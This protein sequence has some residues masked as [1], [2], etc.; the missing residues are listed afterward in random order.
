M[1]PNRPAARPACPASSWWPSGQGG[2]PPRFL[3]DGSPAIEDRG[4]ASNFGTIMIGTAMA[5]AVVGRGCT[6]R[7]RTA[8]WTADVVDLGCGS[9]ASAHERLLP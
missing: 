6:S 3:S 8:R 2:R 5:G 9:P 1:I 4:A 7:P